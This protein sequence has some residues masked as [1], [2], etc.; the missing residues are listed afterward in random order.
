MGISDWAKRK[1][2]DA[3][4]YAKK[5]VGTEDI[6]KSSEDIKKMAKVILSPKKAI[7]NSKK[8]TFI[9]AK[10]RLKVSDTDISNN[11]KNM[12]Y[13]FYISFAFGVLC[14]IG[15]L[16]SLFVRAN[17]LSALSMLA[18]LGICLANSFKFS[19]RAFQIKH[20]KLCSVKEWWDRAGEWFPKLP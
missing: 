10:E 11:Y 13:G 20:Q 16:H 3:K 14:F 6:K 2:S 5:I 9:Q 17:I 15:I 19:F 12:V 8:E 4:E 18:I 7:E 1:G